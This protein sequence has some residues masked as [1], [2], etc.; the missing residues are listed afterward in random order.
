MPISP[1][2]GQGKQCLAPAFCHQVSKYMTLAGL[3]K[4]FFCIISLSVNLVYISYKRF[5]HSLLMKHAP[6]VR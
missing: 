5:G 1:K 2:E 4:R 6:G 3:I